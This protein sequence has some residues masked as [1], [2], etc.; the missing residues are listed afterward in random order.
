MND[1]VE[2]TTNNDFL[3][4]CQA[5]CDKNNIGTLSNELIEEKSICIPK[6]GLTLVNH[7]LASKYFPV[8]DGIFFNGDK[9]VTERRG[10]Y[11]ISQDKTR[12]VFIYRNGDTYL[13]R[14]SKK[15]VEELEASGYRRMKHDY[16]V[17]VPLQPGET[18][19]DPELKRKW[20]NI[21]KDAE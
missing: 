11:N 2:T 18:I 5:W 20:D 10:K 14:N 9:L 6:E 12:L 17:Y 16:E 21:M 15:T 3:D 1:I 8:L 19:V 13:T 4:Y 7:Y